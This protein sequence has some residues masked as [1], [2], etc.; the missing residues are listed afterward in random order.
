M[1][2]VD[3]GDNERRG[4]QASSKSEHGSSTRAKSGSSSPSPESNNSESRSCSPSKSGSRSRHVS[5]G[6]AG[7]S[8]SPSHPCRQRSSS[9]SDSPDFRRRKN[10][11][12]SPM[13]NRSPQAGLRNHETKEANSHGSITDR[14]NPDP[15]KCLGVF[16]LSLETR[17]RELREVFSQYGPLAGIKVVFH[18]R[19]RRSR[20]YAFVY[21]ERLED[22]K[23]A[24]AKANGM[25][26][27][28]KVI[29]VDYSITKRAHSPTPG[30]YMGK[31][32]IDG[33]EEEDDGGGSQR[34][35]RS[36]Y[37]RS[38]DRSYERSYDKGY[39]RS[40][41][42]DYDRNYDRNYDKKHYRSYERSYARRDDRGYDRGYER[43]YDR[44]D[45][46]GYNR[47]YERGYDR[48]YDRSYNRSYN[49]CDSYDE[50]DY[51]I[52]RRRSPSPDY[53]RYRNSSWSRSYNQRRY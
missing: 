2:G 3:E 33:D 9:H 18:H 11:S 27:D 45:D 25:E 37:D 47:G 10:R 13:S 31:P 44:S 15:S 29:R 28:G 39:D 1:S 32:T 14:A 50:Y 35:R 43:G 19:S 24:M 5:D 7:R 23:E 48:G 20:G 40:H 41:D 46:R 22:S 16:G 42:R 8:R 4:S 52:S 36:Y 53:I 30:I 26:I 51:R 38:Y 34:G 49:R 17:A 12:T 21:F 6:L